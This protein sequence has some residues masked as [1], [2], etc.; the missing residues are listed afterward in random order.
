M[1]AGG[2]ESRI[3]TSL[4]LGIMQFS[5]LPLVCYLPGAEKNFCSSLKMESTP[6]KKNGHS[7]ERK[8]TLQ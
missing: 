4:S 7:S 3:K 1:W 6:D 8:L 2:I 5:A